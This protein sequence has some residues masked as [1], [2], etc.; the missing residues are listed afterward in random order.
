MSYI[1]KTSSDNYEAFVEMGKDPATGKR[2][3]E[4]KTFRTKKDAK[5]WMAKKIQEK[6]L[7][8]TFDPGNYTIKDY[9][10]KWLQDYCEPNLSPTTYRGYETIVKSHL[11]PTLGALK[12]KELK[13]MHI[14]SYQSHKLR[15]GRQDGNKGG[16]SKKTLLQ[17]HRVLSKALKQAVQWQLIPI[18]PANAISA[19]RPNSPEIKVLN[20]QEV[21]LLLKEAFKINK[22]TYNLIFILVYTGMRRGEILGLRWK[23]VDLKNKTIQVRKNLIRKTGKGLILKKPKTKS[24]I[25]P[26]KISNRV[27]QIFKT[28]K[29]EQTENRLLLGPDYN[30]EHNL[31]FCKENGVPY[32]PSTANN[33][34]KKV[35][36]TIGLEGFGLHSLRHTHA[37]LLLKAE[38]H[39]KIVQE[40]L[41]H[42]S[43]NLTLDTYSHVIPSMQKESV[44]KFDDIMNG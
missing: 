11:I 29:K 38:V 23:D 20:K 3:R 15:T 16:L 43:I 13:P 21:N 39:P 5:V 33:R 31:V 9:L 2:K 44:D 36:D 37:T 19:P 25:R 41:G 42:S 4:T 40:R 1:R 35:A 14:Q 34:F 7:G 18:N 28:I 27:I 30:T 10:L 22:W 32:S 26:I 24:S 12:L 8:I 17:H 6:E